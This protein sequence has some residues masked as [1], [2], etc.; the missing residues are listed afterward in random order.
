MYRCEECGHLFEEGEQVV[1]IE[2][3][4]LSAPPYE[5]FSGCP[6]CKGTYSEEEDSYYEC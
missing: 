2:K 3:H 5:R 6:I 4:G 1:W